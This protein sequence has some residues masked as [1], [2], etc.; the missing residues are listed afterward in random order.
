MK[1]DVA[2]TYPP[3]PG[4]PQGELLVHCELDVD[5]SPPCADAFVRV[6]TK[7]EPAVALTYTVPPLPEPASTA[8]VPSAK[9]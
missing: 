3:P 6:S 7:I 1:S 8:L 9:S 5:T 4:N 2:N